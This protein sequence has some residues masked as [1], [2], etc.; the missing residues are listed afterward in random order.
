MSLIAAAWRGGSGYVGCA[1]D[2]TWKKQFHVP[3]AAVAEALA[4]GLSEKGYDTYFSCG[5]FR[6]DVGRRA[7]DVSE[8]NAFWLDID[9]GE[10][11][12]K[13]RDYPDLGSAAADLHAWHKRY[14]FPKASAIVDSGSGLHVYWLLDKPVTRDEWLPVARRLAQSL[15]VAGVRADST[16]TEDTASV[17]RV[18]GTV[19]LKYGAPRAVQYIKRDGPRTTLAAMQAALPEFSGPLRSMPKRAAD[20]WSVPM[21]FPPS[22]APLVADRCQQIGDVV[23]AGGAVPEP[24][25]RG[26]LS[27]AKHCEDGRAYAHEWSRGDPRYSAADTD[28]KLEGIPAPH[29]CAGI[30]AANPGGC[31]GCPSRG[32]VKSPIQLG[33]QPAETAVQDVDAEPWRLSRIGPFTVGAQG[34]SCI[35]PAPEGEPAEIVRVCELPVWV[36]AVNTVQAYGEGRKTTV[37]LRVLRHHEGEVDV[38]LPLDVLASGGRE[39][40]SWLGTEMLSPFIPGE[41]AMAMFTRAISE[42]TAEFLR[43]QSAVKEYPHLGW[44]DE[45][46]VLGDTLFTPGGAKRIKPK[47]K[48][49]EYNTHMAS[50]SLDTWK[51]AIAELCEAGPAQRAI[52]LLGFASPILGLSGKDGA[53]VSV[54]GDSG[55][56][57]S[58]MVKAAASIYGPTEAFVTGANDTP[59]AYTLR[60]AAVRNVMVGFDESTGLTDRKLSDFIYAAANG[61]GRSTGTRT[62]GVRRTGTWNMLTFLTSNKSV[63][64]FSEAHINEAN[65]R[66][67]IELALLGAAKQRPGSLADIG[68][69]RN[70]GL[71]AEVYLPA[72]VTLREQLPQ[73][74]FDEVSRIQAKLP[75]GSD[76]D[77]YAHWA[78]AA[79]RLGGTIA[80]GLGLIDFDVDGTVNWLCKH[81]SQQSGE[82]RTEIE[83]A[84]EVL[85]DWLTSNTGN[86]VE[87]SDHGVRMNDVREPIARRQNGM[88]LIHTAPLWEMLRQQHVARRVFQEWVTS[89]GGR[90]KSARVDG[91]GSSVRCLE[92]PVAALDQ[93]EESE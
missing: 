82:T 38:E 17:L 53:V 12:G 45:G 57:K 58:T 80:K 11:N 87:W 28:A 68:T 9:V 3:S 14:D 74:F 66:R 24:R 1:K 18:P 5:A 13:P 54:C 65:R 25:W 15:R 7:A 40:R 76:A 46:F 39:F 75:N 48:Y 36:R 91:A 73:L 41:K 26:A 31:N 23:R 37:V 30:E 43:Q 84:P 85:A 81:F 6:S 62:G 50:G 89:A 90:F 60:M 64:E 72:L 93:K 47:T 20:E 86:I 32:K 44:Y 61:V 78:F 22:S 34:I 42:M 16:R 56:G 69:S 52:M 2:G 71:A 27:I 88:L 77:R 21:Q 63:L 92:I 33:V 55:A 59:V 51:K 10:K 29:T 35:L 70:Y 83:R 67:V 8:L 79:A 4:A 19:N 49:E